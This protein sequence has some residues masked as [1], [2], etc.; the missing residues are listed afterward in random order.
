MRS[1]DVVAHQ[2]LGLLVARRGCLT[3]GIQCVDLKCVAPCK[4]HQIVPAPTLFA[5]WAKD[6]GRAHSWLAEHAA[7]REKKVVGSPGVII[8]QHDHFEIAVGLLRQAVDTPG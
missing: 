5:P 1:G 2:Y 4:Q 6:V 3:K 8:S 7:R